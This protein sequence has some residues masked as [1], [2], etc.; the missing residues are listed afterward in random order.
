M[1]TTD[2][3]PRAV[4]G[5]TGI[6]LVHPVHNAGRD[7]AH[8]VVTGVNTDGTVNVLVHP[9][10]D[11]GP[12]RLTRLP[13]HATRDT[14]DAVLEEHYQYLPGHKTGPKGE[15]VPGTNPQTDL[16]WNPYDAL[17]WHPAFVLHGGAG[18]QAAEPAPAS[19]D[20]VE[21]RLAQLRAEKARRDAEAND[22]RMAEIRALEAELAK[23]D[24]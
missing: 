13:V 21:Q 12:F 10:T 2:T 5:D 19:T 20:P 3:K 8:A 22:P 18:D 7:S 16:P 9:D 6:A 4:V 14:H 17:Y 11:A 15:H 1:T 23:A 24:G